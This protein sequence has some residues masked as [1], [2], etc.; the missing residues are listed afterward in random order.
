MARQEIKVTVTLMSGERSEITI[1]P[2]HTA[3]DVIAVLVQGGK[4]PAQDSTGNLL[5]Y[6]L[7]DERTMTLLAADKPL[8]DLGITTGADLRVKPGARVAEGR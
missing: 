8:V 3:Q 1:A 2:T 6:E 5:Q 4:L 7:V